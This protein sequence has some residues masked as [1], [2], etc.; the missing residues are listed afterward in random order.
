MR[1]IGHG[2]R[3]LTLG[4][5][6]GSLGADSSELD[7]QERGPGSPAAAGGEGRARER[8]RVCEMR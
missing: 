4:R 1:E 5:S 8:V 3:C 6:S 2:D 7:G